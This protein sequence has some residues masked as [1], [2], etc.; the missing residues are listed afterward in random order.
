MPTVVE[1][2]LLAGPATFASVTGPA[3]CRIGFLRLQLSCRSWSGGFATLAAMRR[4]LCCV[5]FS[6]SCWADR[7][8][9]RSRP[10]EASSQPHGSGARTD[11]L[12][13]PRHVRPCAT[14]HNALL[15]ALV[16]MTIDAEQAFE[17]DHSIPGHGDYDLRSHRR[18]WVGRSCTG[19]LARTSRQPDSSRRQGNTNAWYS[20]LS[21]T[22]SSKSASAGAVAIGLQ[23]KSKTVFSMSKA[24]SKLFKTASI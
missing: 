11:V 24:S 12:Q 17:K 1:L 8:P 4:A 3:E 14:D 7:F 20:P 15:E 21:L 9:F 13:P 18:Q 6:K 19:R 16:W 23:S 2:E 5:R 10:R 22:L